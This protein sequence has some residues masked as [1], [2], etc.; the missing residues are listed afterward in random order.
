[1]DKDNEE[2][3]AI[4]NLEQKLYDPKRKID[5]M[6]FHHVRDRAE[7]QLPTSWG[8]TTSVITPVS[9]EHGFSFGA[10][11]LMGASILLF[12]VLCFTAWR[13]LS[14]RNVV[15]EKNID[16]VLDIAPYIEGG[17]STPLV[18]SLTNRNQVELT[19]AS[20]TLMYKQGTGAQDEQEK[21]QVRRELG[22]VTSGDLKRQDFDVVLYGSE[23]EARDI[24][25]KLE[26]KVPGSNA[27]FSKVVVSQVVLKSPPLSIRIEGPDSL[28]AGQVGAFTV[29]V[30]NNTGTTTTPSLVSLVLPTNFTIN[31]T[32]PKASTRGNLWQVGVLD[33]GVS[34]T[35]KVVGTLSGSGGEVAT[36]RA[37]IG[38]VGGSVSEVGV[39][40][41][42]TLLDVKLRSS[43]LELS[44]VLSTDRG[45]SE[46]LRY[47][48]KA[49]IA[50]G[51]KNTSSEPLHDVALVLRIAGDAALMK[52]ITS[53]EGYYNS[54]LGTITWDTA[55][56][57]ALA[58]MPAGKEGTFFVTIPIVTKGTNAP[59]LSVTVDASAT[60]KE[61]DDVTS[62]VSKS[63]VVQGSASVSART[64]YKN[65]SFQ[66]TGPI[67]PQPNVDTTYS[68]HVSVSAQNAL[69]NT[70]VSF[71][72]P[73]YVTWRN[74]GD[75]SKMSY[76]TRTR[77]VTW[78]V[79]AVDAGK[80][81]ATD[82]GVTVRPSQVHVGI[83]PPITGG[84]VLDADEVDSK[85]HIKTTISGATT[86][87][88][89]E[90]W[91]VDPSLVVDR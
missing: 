64:Q 79:G 11:V 13:V 75:T 80:T 3:H 31:E 55:S 56:V 61:K 81:V 68:I 50:V 91:T 36:I 83:S 71:V 16:M 10:K 67:P 51:Y 19:N 48:D 74:I 21:V 4:D 66:N 58:S 35:I 23:A 24:T 37:I 77:T 43:P 33:A 60:L 70:K 52:Q 28:S 47:G 14:L 38:S 20:L 87:I 40:Y 27:L 89:G 62:S 45:Q 2:L 69:E 12:L 30:K 7:K 26:Y 44:A 53:Q 46:N 54:A 34:Y 49:Y 76:D 25:L 41:S 63:F 85:A 29:V 65:S 15:S 22:T 1:M 9:E 88:G 32:T 72:L 73:A 86:Y 82:I 18:V 42:S 8:E 17:E 84:I 6:A 39:V 5:N 59:K 90:S 57:P 78:N